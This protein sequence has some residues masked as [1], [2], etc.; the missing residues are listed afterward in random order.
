MHLPLPYH[1]T[2]NHQNIIYTSNL[3][4]LMITH[5][6]L[7]NL[8]QCWIQSSKKPHFIY[9]INWK[10]TIEKMGLKIVC[11]T[12]W[13]RLTHTCVS[14]L[15]TI[16]LDNGLSPGQCQTSIKTN[17][18]ILLIGP[19]GTNLSEILIIIYPLSFRKMHLK[20]SPGKWWPFCLGLNVLNCHTNSKNRLSWI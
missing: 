18:G 19:L 13:G 4:Y 20:M 14:K 17:A 15:T 8:N 3:F 7:P 1:V 9:H 16:G 5:G 12:H 11:L 2:R 6:L 10:D